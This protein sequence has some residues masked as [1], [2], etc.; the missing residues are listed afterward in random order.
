MALSECAVL[1]S[2]FI[3]IMNSTIIVVIIIIE[4]HSYKEAILL[5][6]ALVP[7]YMH[8]ACGGD[9]AVSLPVSLVQEIMWSRKE[10]RWL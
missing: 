9:T 6:G 10:Q 1:V 7:M 3:I 5:R 4:F 2:I 8:S